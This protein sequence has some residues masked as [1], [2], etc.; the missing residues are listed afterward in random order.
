MLVFGWVVDMRV[1]VLFKVNSI[2]VKNLNVEIN[3]FPKE[4][5]QKDYLHDIIYLLSANEN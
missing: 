3:F 4:R 5:S 2:I 1:N